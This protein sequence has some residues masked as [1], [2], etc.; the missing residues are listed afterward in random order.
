MRDTQ[1]PKAPDMAVRVMQKCGWKHVAIC[2]GVSHRDITILMSAVLLGAGRSAAQGA[3]HVHVRARAARRRNVAFSIGSVPLKKGSTYFLPQAEADHLIH[4]GVMAPS[5]SGPIE[6]FT[7]PYDYIRVRLRLW[8][9]SGPLNGVVHQGL[10]V[11]AC[12]I[13]VYDMVSRVHNGP[14]RLWKHGRHPAHWCFVCVF[15]GLCAAMHTHD[16]R[17][18]KFMPMQWYVGGPVQVLAN[19]NNMEPGWAWRCMELNKLPGHTHAH[20]A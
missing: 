10:K 20:M 5:E 9:D 4:K 18:E 3:G 11:G 13:M 1:P 14:K 17:I 7:T 8:S 16:M 15:Q 2:T 19:Q 6:P 12:A